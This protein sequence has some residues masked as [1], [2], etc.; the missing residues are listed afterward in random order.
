VIKY[1]FQAV[2]GMSSQTMDKPMPNLA[3][4]MMTFLLRTR[5]FFLPREHVLAEVG[6]KPGQRVLDYGCGPGG[7]VAETARLVGESGRVYALDI[8]PLALQKVQTMVRQNN[9]TNV[10]T[11]QSNC[12]T[13]LPDHSID[14]VLLYDI[15]HM[16]SDSQAILAELHRILKPE[17]ILSFSDH[18]MKEDEILTGV[19]RNQLFKLSQRGRKTYTFV[20]A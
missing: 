12:Q 11:I 10:E 7:Y 19:I 4:K 3:F 8:H 9:L 18:H 1:Q 16:F 15:F 13:G 6:L 5:D 17:G 20:K 2:P 14:V